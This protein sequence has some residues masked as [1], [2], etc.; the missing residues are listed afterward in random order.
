MRKTRQ[1]CA[2]AKLAKAPTAEATAGKR[3]KKEKKDKEKKK[4][5]QDR[6]KK[7]KEKGKGSSCSDDSSSNSDGSGSSSPNSS[8][9]NDHR[10]RK[11]Q[12]KKQHSIDPAGV[13]HKSNKRRTS[14]CA[15][16]PMHDWYVES[17]TDQ[18]ILAERARAGKRMYEMVHNHLRNWF[19]DS[20]FGCVG[21]REPGCRPR[22]FQSCCRQSVLRAVLL[23][24]VHNYSCPYSY[25]YS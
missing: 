25:S 18:A 12:R 17:C 15:Y 13:V 21:I 14:K 10:R 7:K 4:K 11:K 5:K 24:N 3:K 22:C 8:D 6:K 2:R 16:G 20:S 23:T 1:S 9:D 19:S